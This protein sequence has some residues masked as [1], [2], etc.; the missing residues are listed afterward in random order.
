M[1]KKTWI[2][3]GLTVGAAA[4]VGYVLWKRAQRA[5]EIP[6]ALPADRVR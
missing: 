1:N 3:S 6:I 4:G 5:V 2:L